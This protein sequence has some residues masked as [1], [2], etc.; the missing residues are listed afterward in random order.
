M[1]PC[2]TATPA[3]SGL[4]AT[5]ADRLV[6]HDLPA[7]P[8][9]RR[10]E[11]VAFSV[12]RVT[13]LPSPMRIGVTAVAL[14]VATASRLL[15]GHRVTGFLASRPLPLFGEYVRLIRSLAFAYVWETWP[16][17]AVDGLPAGVLAAAGAAG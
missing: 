8:P 2:R 11:V 13:G 7:L 5:F 14:A 9:S 4:V 16:D 10:A 3:P 17:T 12:H 15:G 6:A 1:A